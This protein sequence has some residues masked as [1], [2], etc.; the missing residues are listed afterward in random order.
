MVYYVTDLRFIYQV[1]QHVYLSACGKGLVQ[2]YLKC[3][4]II[5]D[6]ETDVRVP[7]PQV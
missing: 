5:Q 2:L 1:N 6:G 3:S 7:R 4:Q